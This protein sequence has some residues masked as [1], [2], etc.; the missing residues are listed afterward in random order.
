MNPALLKNRTPINGLTIDG[1]YSLDLDDAFWL[2]T[3]ELGYILH[4]SIA[5]VGAAV[6][7][8]SLLDKAAYKKCFT[9]YLMKGNDPMLPHD[10]S[11][12][13]LSLHEGKERLSLTVSIPID[14]SGQTASPI[15]RKTI[16]KS[17]AKL[18]YEQ[19]DEIM[20]MPEHKFHLMLKQCHSFSQALFHQRQQNGA[21]ALYNLQKG[22]ALSEEGA[23]TK[24][25]ADEAFHS[26][27]L[28]QEFMVLVNEA[29]AVFFA[30]NQ[31]PALY[32]NHTSKAVAPERQVVLD[33]VSHAIS[34]GDTDRINTVAQKFGMIFNRAAYEPVIAGHY[35]LNLPAYT[36]ITSPIRRYADLIN[37]RQL[38]AFI[39]DETL[40]YTHEALLE[41]GEQINTTL[42]NYKKDQERYFKKEEFQRRL[43]LLKADNVLTSDDDSF[44]PLLKTAITAKQLPASLKEELEKRLENEE[45]SLTD[46]FVILLQSDDSK[47]WVAIKTKLLHQLGRYLYNTT[48]ILTIATQK[49]HWQS[50]KYET[51]YTEGVSLQFFTIASIQIKG[52][53]FSSSSQQNLHITNKKTSQQLAN[54]SLLATIINIELDMEA[55]YNNQSIETNTAS[56]SPVFTAPPQA[57]R[58]LAPNK[59]NFIGK[60]VEL[61]QKKGWNSPSYEYQQQGAS[62]Q[63]VFLVR[64]GIMIDGEMHYS[65]EKKGGNKKEVKQSAS[66]DL[67]KKIAQ[68]PTNISSKMASSK[69]FV[70]LLNTVFQQYKLNLPRYQIDFT[71]DQNIAPFKCICTAVDHD[72]YIKETIGYGANKKEAKQQAAETMLKAL[73]Q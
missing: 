39:S 56:S 12:N 6:E 46:M 4:V 8:D 37:I 1:A 64:A 18:S 24:L 2:E 7:I 16:L 21:M 20:A 35:A 15:I 17:K 42:L 34:F 19:A 71:D 62:H 59:G 3:V 65:D 25:S 40:P 58:P 38:S 63:P 31:I 44:T 26:H 53:A 54:L 60:L 72:E 36:H 57:V 32:R 49:F 29:V 68:F 28:I 33:D 41:I 10:Y 55:I 67:I 13:T 47:Q 50:I 66:A 11:E 48:S 61:A 23:I 73:D 27:I 14:K 69:N 30:E 43:T 9:R 70:G 52:E 5:D 45:L 51:R 22:F